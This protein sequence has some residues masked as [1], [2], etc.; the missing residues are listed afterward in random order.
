[1]AMHEIRRAIKGVTVPA[2]A[3]RRL[4]SMLLGE[5]RNLRREFGQTRAQMGLAPQIKLG[6]EIDGASLRSRFRAPSVTLHD[7][8][9]T[10]F[11]DALRDCGKFLGRT[12]LVC[13]QQ[14]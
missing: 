12:R 4:P 5:Y 13:Q 14:T 7:N 1:M 11:R 2:K 6:D 3:V 10:L 8:L 9:R